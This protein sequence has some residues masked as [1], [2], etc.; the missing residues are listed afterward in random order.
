MAMTG[1]GERPIEPAA[2]HAVRSL[3][4][5]SA[6]SFEPTFVSLDAAHCFH[7]YVCDCICIFFF[8]CFSGQ[9]LVLRSLRFAVQLTMIFAA[10][11][12]A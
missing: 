6:F 12:Y 9:L 8:S 11:C 2:Y 1:L 5:F 10:R 4:T 7:V 3:R